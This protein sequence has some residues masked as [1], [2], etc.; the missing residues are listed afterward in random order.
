MRE[1]PDDPPFLV[2]KAPDGGASPESLR[3]RVTDGLPCT[4]ARPGL[5]SRRAPATRTARATPLSRFPITARGQKSASV[6]C[7]RL[8]VHGYI[9]LSAKAGKPADAG[10]VARP[11]GDAE[12]AARIQQVEQVRGL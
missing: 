5:S 11:L 12:S 3:S 4:V 8:T 7:R 9:A 10:D 6:S 2:P 1:L